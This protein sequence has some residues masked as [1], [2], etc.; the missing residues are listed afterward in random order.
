MGQGWAGDGDRGGGWGGVVGW[1]NGWMGGHRR[2]VGMEV[3]RQAASTA[4][5]A[6]AGEV[7][8]GVLCSRL[9]LTQL[10]IGV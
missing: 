5:I 3:D 6:A 2:W 10:A 7:G 8:A 1:A 4:C 9:W